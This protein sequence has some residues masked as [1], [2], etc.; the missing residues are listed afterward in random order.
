MLERTYMSKP[1]TTS[2]NLELLEKLIV[3]N[4]AENKPQTKRETAKAISKQYKSTWNAFKRLEK[5]KLIKQATTITYNNIE[6]PRYWLTDEGILIAIMEGANLNKLLEQTKTLYPEN[7]NAHCF[8][9]IAPLFDPQLMRMAYS[10]LK[11]KDKIG[12]R[13]I[14]ILFLSQPSIAM[15]GETAKKLVTTLQKY[16]VEYNKLKNA[17]QEMKNQLNQLPF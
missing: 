4:L 6:Y 16:P 7:K 1:K 15:D 5:K 9:E 13:E 12:S 17:V 3:L 11:G 10:S 2:N 14:I 8:L